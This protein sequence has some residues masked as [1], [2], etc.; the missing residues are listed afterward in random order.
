MNLTNDRGRSGEERPP[1][2]KA[3]ASGYDAFTVPHPD[4]IAVLRRVPA[5]DQRRLIARVTELEHLARIMREPGLCTP[6]VT[7]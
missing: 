5:H 6:E 2:S 7:G 1:K 4:V 3:A